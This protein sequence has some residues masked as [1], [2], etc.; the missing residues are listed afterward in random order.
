M[1]FQSP[2][3]NAPK[4]VNCDPN[5]T[6]L[7]CDAR[8]GSQKHNCKY[9]VDQINFRLPRAKKHM[10]FQSPTFNA[11]KIVN[12]DL[13]ATPLECDARLGSQKHHFKYRVDQINFRPPRG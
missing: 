1:T 6:P 11:P 2:T 9:R 7:E 12:C 4:I 3:F 5:A 13:N 8:L 10:T